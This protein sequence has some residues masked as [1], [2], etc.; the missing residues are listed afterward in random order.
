MTV[1]KSY[2]N[3]DS[4]VKQHEGSSSYVSNLCP[5]GTKVQQHT[6]NGLNSCD[7]LHDHPEY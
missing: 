5:P 1:T 4:V 3:T 6:F 2:K 7:T